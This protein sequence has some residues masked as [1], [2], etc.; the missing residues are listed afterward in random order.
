MKLWLWS[1]IIATFICL[2]VWIESSQAQLEA[3]TGSS[4]A[5]IEDTVLGIYQQ[6]LDRS[7]SS[8]ELVDA[9]RN[10]RDGTWTEAGLRQ[11]LIDS[12]EY[13]RLIKTQ[14]NLLTP[15][16]TKMI[17]DRAIIDMISKIYEEEKQHAI[18][19]DLILPLKAAFVALDYNEY[20][21]RALLRAPKYSYFEADVQ[22]AND[23]T[24]DTV[25]ALL[26]KHVG[27]LSTL[28]AQ[29]KELARAA[30]FTTTNA[31][32]TASSLGAG[33]SGNGAGAGS[34]EVVGAATS[35]KPARTVNDTDGNMSPMIDAIINRS[36]RV[37]DK[38]ELAKMIDQQYTE[39]YRIPSRLHYGDMVLRP[40]MSWSVPQERPPVC[41][42]L[43]QKQLVQ[44]VMVNSA[45]LLGTPLDEATD[46]TQVG[47]IMPGF[48]YKEFVDVKVK[49]D[50]AQ[51]DQP[52][53]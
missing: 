2:G 8:T 45:L 37:F 21:F 39:T 16:L 47:S 28:E 49:K 15:E 11:R 5:T 35:D 50:G 53:Q 51:G 12:D 48:E 44:P 30:Q 42:S 43:G 34:T 17:A 41:T 7:P 20:A 25:T 6:V 52:I 26:D 22:E 38:D 9:T 24:I 40:D 1:V 27:G 18:P 10:L 31:Q 29:G 36:Q 46:N 14:S 23:V 3:F 4:A 19:D 32:L 33:A 13:Q